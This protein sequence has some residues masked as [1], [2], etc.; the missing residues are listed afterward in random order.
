MP[1]YKNETQSPISFYTWIWNPGETKVVMGYVPSS[2]NLTKIDS[3]PVIDPLLY[4]NESL[5]V[6]V[7]TPTEIEIPVPTLSPIYHISISVATGTLKL[8]FN[9]ASNKEITVGANEIFDQSMYWHIAP[10]IIL[11]ATTEAFVSIIVSEMTSPL[12]Y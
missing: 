8:K 12:V 6:P 1:T 10:K 2:L 5:T 9:D 7:G 3:S 4:V 11:N